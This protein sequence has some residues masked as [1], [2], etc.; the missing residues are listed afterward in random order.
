MQGKSLNGYPFR[1][2]TNVNAKVIGPN[3]EIKQNI[4]KHNMAT[5]NL[6]E[7]VVKFLRGEFTESYISGLIPNIGNNF[8]VADQYIP[9]Y[10]GI[11]VAGVG[12]NDNLT[13]LE[14]S[15]ASGFAPSYADKQLISEILPMARPGRAIV[16]KSVRSNASL[17]QAAALVISTAYHFEDE[18]ETQ[19]F[20]IEASTESYRKGKQ[21]YL[22]DSLY[23]GKNINQRIKSLSPRTAG[24][25]YMETTAENESTQTRATGSI[26]YTKLT[27]T[28]SNGVLSEPIEVFS[29]D[30][31]TGTLTLIPE[32]F[33]FTAGLT[34]TYD[35]VNFDFIYADGS[36]NTVPFI[37]EGLKRTYYVSELGLFSGD[38][39]NDS[40]KLLARVLLDPETPM[41]IS[42]GDYVV[43]T[44]QVGVYALDDALYVDDIESAEVEDSSTLK[45][46]TQEE[47][48]TLLWDEITEVDKDGNVIEK[49]IA[50]TSQATNNIL[51]MDFRDLATTGIVYFTMDDVAG[52]YK[53]FSMDF[54]CFNGTLN[55]TIQDIKAIQPIID[56]EP[57]ALEDFA[58]EVPA[59]GIVN[60]TFETDAETEVQS[61]S[62]EYRPKVES[63]ILTVKVD[64]PDTYIKNQ[65][66]CFT[67]ETI[68]T[69]DNITCT[70]VLNNAPEQLGPVTYSYSLKDITDY[71]DESI[72]EMQ[73]KG[74]YGLIEIQGLSVNAV[75][76][77][78]A[79]F[80]PLYYIFGLPVLKDNDVYTVTY[81]NEENILSSDI[82]SFYV[83]GSISEMYN[84]GIGNLYYVYE[85][86]QEIPENPTLPITYDTTKYHIELVIST[87]P[88]TNK[89]SLIYDLIRIEENLDGTTSRQDADSIIFT[90][91]YHT[92]EQKG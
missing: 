59:E 33:T 9:A 91:I 2:E 80:N 13:G 1:V 39:N 76:S 78:M 36:S 8:N 81:N 88:K 3:R 25:S 75:D 67:D 26:Y 6:T 45:Y 85:V 79:K 51:A 31:N 58:A 77:D 70:Q 48:T 35:P 74:R 73:Y 4:D 17:S 12:Y 7:G 92:T 32:T 66:T 68:F 30:F 65:F 89:R 46:I 41:K 63:Y 86:T 34:I 55:G 90:N 28:K 50:P 23:P 20:N 83:L 52:L 21:F 71:T 22:S 18:A 42:E 72:S 54:E 82:D 87:D 11:G 84:E 49:E 53:G 47:Q 37:S 44:W 27:E 57:H 19:V 40:S 56:V 14:V 60:L 62:Y 10:M 29:V 38:I 61:V 5:A 15:T 16:S 69:L 43:I 24:W 64:N